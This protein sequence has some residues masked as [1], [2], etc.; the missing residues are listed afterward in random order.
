MAPSRHLAWARWSQLG[1]VRMHMCSLT[2]GFRKGL[3]DIG[4][5]QTLQEF[6]ARFTLS[7]KIQLI[8]YLLGMQQ[9]QPYS[10]REFSK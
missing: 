6:H 9:M 4:T 10:F 1:R 8:S 5:G 7:R 2:T 3:L